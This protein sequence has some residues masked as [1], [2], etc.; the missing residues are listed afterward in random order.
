MSNTYDT[1]A[2]FPQTLTVE[3]YGFI[4]EISIHRNPT[5]LGFDVFVQRIY[6]QIQSQFCP[7]CPLE[8]VLEARKKAGP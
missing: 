4:D 5:K 8:A 1:N 7:G 6:E 3:G 2:K